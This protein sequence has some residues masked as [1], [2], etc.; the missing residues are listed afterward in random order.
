M[1]SSITWVI[2]PIAFWTSRLDTRSRTLSTRTT[3]TM[4]GIIASANSVSFQLSH[5]RKAS[6]P[7]MASESRNTMVSALVAA[8][9]TWVTSNVSLEMSTPVGCRS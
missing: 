1:A 9:V 3:T 2:W 6:R 8:A 7:T 5:S 4:R